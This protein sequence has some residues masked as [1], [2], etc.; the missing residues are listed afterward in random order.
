LRNHD[1]RGHGRALHVPVRRELRH[2]LNTYAVLQGEG[3]WG[4]SADNDL[5]VSGVCSCC[6]TAAGANQSADERTLATP[7]E[8]ANECASAATAADKAG[9]AFALAA[10]STAPDA[11][12]DW[13]AISSDP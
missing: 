3:K 1:G 5:L 10:E 2:H 4:L 7:G 12:S 6:G 8:A 9:S 11:G 13:G